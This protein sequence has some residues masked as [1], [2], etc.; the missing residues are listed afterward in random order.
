MIDKLRL[1]GQLFALLESP[2]VDGL[3]QLV[4]DLPE[5]R[6]ITRGVQ[7]AEEARERR[8]VYSFRYLDEWASVVATVESLASREGRGT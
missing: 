1:R 6:T 5:D 7:V 3:T 8:H 4:G 2:T